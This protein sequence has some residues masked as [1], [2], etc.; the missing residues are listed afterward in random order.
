VPLN[1]APGA[2]GVVSLRVQAADVEPGATSQSLELRYDEPSGERRT[3]TQLVG[4][5]VAGDSALGP[6]PLID[7]YRTVSFGSGN[8]D[9]AE[10]MLHP[11][12]V[13]DLVLDVANVGLAAAQR[14]RLT[15][16][17]ASAGAGSAAASGGSGLGVFAPVGT[18]NV[19]FLGLLAAGESRQVT[20][21][22]V[23]DGAAKPG[24]YQ[25]PIVFAYVDD[26]GQMQETSEV[27]S[28]LVSRPV[29]LVI[30]PITV[31][32]ETLGLAPFPF[33]AEITNAG[34]GTVKVG[35]VI[36]SGSAGL[37]IEDGRR[38]IGPLD[39]GALD[40]ID[41]TVIPREPGRSVVTLTV[42]YTDD[43]NRPGK[44]EREFPVEVTEANEAAPPSEGEP[45]P[46]GNVVVRIIKGLLGLGA[47]PPETGPAAAP[48]G[49]PLEESPPRAPAGQG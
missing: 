5:V 40:T 3:D 17:A 29:N 1:L 28:L 20:Q 27:I 8:D 45:R 15:L 41:A 11:G 6:M 9:G 48:A 47:S 21:S 33:S 38:F 49:S 32:T 46:T 44:V 14:T 24:V 39:A 19:R 2:S 10:A 37:R 16:G 18:S 31:V 22:M 30:T 34:D 42:N 26:D 25:L 23:I 43:F 7:A 12:Q 35:E 13:F 36:V 4:V